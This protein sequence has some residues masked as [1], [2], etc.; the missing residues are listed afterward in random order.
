M[1]CNAHL[2]VKPP[3]AVN[4]SPAQVLKRG[5]MWLKQLTLTTNNDNPRIPSAAQIRDILK[6]N[7]EQSIRGMQTEL[8]WTNMEI[9]QRLNRNPAL[10]DWLPRIIANNIKILQTQNSTYAQAEKVCTSEPGMTRRELSRQNNLEKLQFVMHVLH[11]T[12]DNIIARPRSLDAS[13]ANQ[14]G[15][16]FEFLCRC[17]LKILQLLSATHPITLQLLSFQMLH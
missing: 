2:F 14:I 16:R 7:M 9:T 6:W 8:G 3:P 1:T 12:P 10:L 5:S 17:G 4:L 13:L 11:M 15:P